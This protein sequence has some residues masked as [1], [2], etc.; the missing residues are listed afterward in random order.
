MVHLHS[1]TVFIPESIFATP[2]F[3]IRSIPLPLG[4]STV[5]R[6]DRC[7]C[8]LPA[9]GSTL[10]TFPF[11]F[12]RAGQC[13]EDHHFNHSLRGHTSFCHAA[14]E[15][16]GSAESGVAVRADAVEVH[17]ARVRPVTPVRH[18]APIVAERVCE[19]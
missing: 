12:A 6:F 8:E 3:P 2:F 4:R 15:E 9:D 14:D 19:G 1:A 5:G 16:P 7:A 10:L 11:Q 17:E 18:T 13:I